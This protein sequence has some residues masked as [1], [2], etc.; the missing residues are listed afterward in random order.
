[1][2]VWRSC[3]LLHGFIVMSC[4]T[5]RFIIYII[6]DDCICKVE[7]YCVEFDLKG[8]LAQYALSCFFI[9]VVFR[10]FDLQLPIVLFNVFDIMEIFEFVLSKI[11]L[12]WF[13]S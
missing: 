1:V 11:G 9:S 4:I 10:V 7:V 13:S 2:S 6:I 12:G 5:F 8:A 3:G